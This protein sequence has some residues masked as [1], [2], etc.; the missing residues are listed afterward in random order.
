MNYTNTPLVIGA[1]GGSG[2]RT[3]A[4]IC[5]MVGYYMGANVNQFLD[6]LEFVPFYN[7]WINVT[8]SSNR[9]ILTEEQNK[10]MFQDFLA[11][12]QK[13]RKGIKHQAAP[14]GW[15]NP[16]SMYL[17]PFFHALYPTMRFIHII[18]DGRDVALLKDS[19]QLLFH[20]RTFFDKQYDSL[21]LPYRL[22]LL[23]K[24]TNL[25]IASFGE[26]NMGKNY[27][28]IRFEDLCENPRGIVVRLVKFLNV[29]NADVSKLAANIKKPNTVGRWHMFPVDFVEQI[30]ELGRD[31]LV[32]FGYI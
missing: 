5:R 21:L 25:T 10:L 22:M 30:V 24:A 13:H 23:W 29:R 7:K 9:I 27:L 19:K 12:I 32:K 31:G 4:Q 15:K 14:W 16:R 6:A 3:I 11:C 28:R 26:K 20:T 18:R 2:T 8:L 17:L 1:T